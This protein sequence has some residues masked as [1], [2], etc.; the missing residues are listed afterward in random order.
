MAS[1]T[2]CVRLRVPSFACA[3]LKWL[4][5][6]SS[7]RPSAF[8][9]SCIVRPIDACRN[10]DLLPRRQARART[11]ALYIVTNQSFQANSGRTGG[12]IEQTTR[13]LREAIA[14]NSWRP[15]RNHPSSTNGTHDTR[16]ACHASV[17]SS[18][19]QR[20]IPIGSSIL[21]SSVHV[22]G[23]RHILAVMSPMGWPLATN[24]D[25]S[26]SHP[27]GTS[28]CTKTFLPSSMRRQSPTLTEKRLAPWTR[29]GFFSEVMSCNLFST[30]SGVPRPSTSI[31]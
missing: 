18:K 11:N 9:V 4:R 30:S 5:T 21:E 10:T 24:A 22:K 8:A 25:H 31:E 29:M 26:S 7:P 6:V 12:H 2:V 20:S 16:R 3:F 15:E 13:L 14:K 27:G 28:R 17:A 23:A 1:A 19:G